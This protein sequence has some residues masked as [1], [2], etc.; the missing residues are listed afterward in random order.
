[1][2]LCVFSLPISLVMIERTYTLSYHHHQIGMNYYPLFRVRSSNNGMRSMSLYILTESSRSLQCNNTPC[3]DDFKHNSWS[4]LC[5]YNI[6]ITILC[7]SVY[8][9]RPPCP[10]TSPS[11]R[12]SLLSLCHTST[13]SALCNH[14]HRSLISAIVS[15]LARTHT[16]TFLSRADSRFAPSQWETVLLCKPKSALRLICLLGICPPA[17]LSSMRSHFQFHWTTNCIKH[18]RTLTWTQHSV[19]NIISL[20]NVD[21]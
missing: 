13:L 21:C 12:L 1:M 15:S 18:I 5:S 20:S 10:S 9:S 11:R 17:C 2:G 7:H 19:H 8:I 14:R 16:H 6:V 3:Q 4:N